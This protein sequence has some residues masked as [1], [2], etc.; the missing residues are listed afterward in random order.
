MS[1]LNSKSNFEE[2]KISFKNVSKDSPKLQSTSLPNSSDE[3]YFFRTESDLKT[4]PPSFSN[5]SSAM[6]SNNH[7]KILKVPEKNIEK[8]SERNI[9]KDLD[10]SSKLA[11]TIL[12]NNLDMDNSS[13]FLNNRSANAS[14]TY[15]LDSFSDSQISSSGKILAPI[16]ETKTLIDTPSQKESIHNN[17]YGTRTSGIKLFKIPKKLETVSEKNTY[18]KSDD[19][20]DIKSKKIINK[21]S[22]SNTKS[23]DAAKF[24]SDESFINQKKSGSILGSRNISGSSHK[25]VL[26]QENNRA[27]QSVQ[28]IYDSAVSF[29]K[30][31]DYENASKLFSNVLTLQPGH[32]QSKIRLKQCR[33]AMHHAR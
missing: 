12:S 8:N 17:A 13:R 4:A 11:E 7:T 14:K 21:K 16:L 25:S 33:E 28:E 31:K 9:E 5:N 2:T 6:H 26:H 20:S 24:N 22:S 29:M 27:V 32:I 23:L 15:S 1:P 19:S 30:K 3:Q 18:F 10:K